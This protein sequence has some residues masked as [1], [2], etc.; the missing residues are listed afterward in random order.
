MTNPRILL[1][2]YTT[3]IGFR[4]DWLRFAEE[5]PDIATYYLK[6]AEYWDTNA[7][8]DFLDVLINI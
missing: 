3:S 6:K 4:D 7:A 1:N 5:R 2:L 8:L